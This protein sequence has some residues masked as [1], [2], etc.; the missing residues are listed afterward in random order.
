MMTLFLIVHAQLVFKSLA[1]ALT[2]EARTDKHDFTKVECLVLPWSNNS[3]HEK[4]SLT[5]P[6]LGL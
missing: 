4:P 1:R 3:F 5:D 2:V 6:L